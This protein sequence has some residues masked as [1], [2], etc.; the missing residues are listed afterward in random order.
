[1]TTLDRRSFIAAGA[2]GVPALTTLAA[3]AA[4]MPTATRPARPVAISSGNGM[5]AVTRAME[6]LREGADPVEAVVAGVTLV[7]D[8]PNDASVGYGGIPNEDGVVQLDASVMHGPTHKAGAVAGIERIRNPAAVALEV[9]RRT[10]HVLL[11]GDGARR[12][13]VA[14]GFKEENLLTERAREAWVKWKHNLNPND[15]W[16]D[17]S[18]N[19]EIDPRQARAASLGI[20][21]HYGTIHCSAVDA[22]GDL[23]AT[24]TTSGLS[25]KIPGRVGDSPIIGA[26]MFV[27]NAV[28]AAGSTGR[29][30]SV[31][32]S[33]GAFQVVRNMADGMEP[34]EAAFQVVKWIADHTKRPSLLNAEGEPNFNVIMYALRKDGAVGGAIMRGG[35][36]FAVHDG[37]E[38]KRVRLRPLF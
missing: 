17:D 6:L 36:A 38:A 2:A 37:V 11:V 14:H 21:W 29:G 9:L 18:Q 30:E 19:V 13:A 32:Q 7:E 31:I 20:P 35:N 5:P 22:N 26:G 16:L 1:M 10:D 28:G 33:C 34:E 24:T 8:D 3:H 12:F 27:D 15:D 23:G 25:Y 4:P